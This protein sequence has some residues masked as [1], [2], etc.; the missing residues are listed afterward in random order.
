MSELRAAAR[1]GGQPT[2][3][4]Q[5]SDIDA[6]AL[7]NARENAARAGVKLELR[8]L[9]LSDV[10]PASANGLLVSNP[11]YGERLGSSADLPRQLARLVD[12][13]PDHFAGLLMAAEQNLVRTRRKPK[14]YS[15][16]NGDIACTLRC[17]TP[18]ERRADSER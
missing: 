7:S 15:L 13:F 16:F 14:L 5:G 12:R 6:N 3:S 18:I 17:Y 2:P 9:P 4:M 8:Q 11:P 10:R 1:G